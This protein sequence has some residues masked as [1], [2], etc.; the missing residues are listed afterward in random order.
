MPARPSNANIS[1]PAAPM[2]YSY[3]G[4]ASERIAALSG[5]VDQLRPI[6]EAWQLGRS[7]A[8]SGQASGQVL[9][10]LPCTSYAEL[11]EYWRKAM[12]WRSEMDNVL[13]FMFAI[14]ISTE[15]VGDQLFA[16]IIGDAGSG[17]TR[18][19]D[20]ML[21][22]PR[23]HALEHITGFHS[24]W[25]DG[26]GDD[27]SLIS[28]INRKTLIT[29]EGDTMI[30]SGKFAE[31][32]SQQRRIFDGTTG[33]TYKNRK[34]D[35][36]HTG[37]R[38]PWII[39]GTQS[40]VD[41][42]AADQSRLGDRFL[43]QHFD[44]PDD[45]EKKLILRRVAET[46]W[47]SLKMTS[48]G[49]ASTQLDENMC[50]AYQ[51]TGGFVN[52]LRDNAAEILSTIDCR[53][54]RLDQCEILGD[55]ISYLRA[56]P[57]QQKGGEATREVPTR[58]TSQFVRTAGCL[59][60]VL[61]KNEVDDEVMHRVK[62]VAL[63]TG[64]GISFD[65]VRNML[66]SPGGSFVGEISTEINKPADM[67]GGHLRFM[68][69]IRICETVKVAGAGGRGAQFKWMMKNRVRNLLTEIEKF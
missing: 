63:D 64:R 22:S 17:K 53:N 34:D 14:A 50:A 37:L 6:P 52:H 23:C 66:H 39:A 5:L 62:K 51:R 65:I 31:I 26:S 54:E 33:A 1:V 15:Q 58:L 24:G 12:R 45:S 41:H 25:N 36:K 27:F 28:R 11:L 10:P 2:V 16:M 8:S 56:R 49:E 4:T 59:A 55:L 32:M 67:L 47:S 20:A 13:A 19:C 7:G 42:F 9:A 29:P 35:V 69:Q 68:K 61:G 43:K 30:G 44:Q 48:D 60:A 46:A 38:T 18:F 57:P 21:V 3:L 40:L